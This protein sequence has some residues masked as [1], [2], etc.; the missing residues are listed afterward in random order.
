[1]TALQ[2]IISTRILSLKGAL[3]KNMA[4]F[5]REAIKS[6]FIRLLEERQFSEITVKNIVEE[7]GI[8]RNSFYYHFQDLPSLL[9]EIIRE[10]SDAVIAKYSSVNSIVECFDAIEEF[11]SNRKRTIMHI[12]RSVSRDVFERYLMKTSEYFI[13]TYIDAL[14]AEG[15]IDQALISR[16]K[17]LIVG[18][19]KCLFFGVIIEWLESGMDEQLARDFRRIFRLKADTADE[20]A[21]IL[22]SQL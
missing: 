14:A 5:T 19:Y 12:Y 7:C 20:L 8:N 21:E 10:E 18:Y 6:T 4:N 15:E 11:A 1:M 2:R 16:N 9:E 22:R 17:S 3:Y 13:S